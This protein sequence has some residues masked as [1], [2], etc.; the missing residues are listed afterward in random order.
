M[1]PRRGTGGRACS[2]DSS[3]RFTS[4]R[5]SYRT[6]S[7]TAHQTTLVHESVPTDDFV[8]YHEARARG[9]TGL[10]VLEATAVH[11]SGL[12]TAHTLA[13]YR[14]EIVPG[15]A[16]VARR[17][18]CLRHASLRAA[19]SRRAGADL[20]RSTPARG[21]SLRDPQPPLPRR[22]APALREGD[23]FDP[24]G[25]RALGGAGGPGRPRRS[26]DLGG[27]PVPCRS[28]L[29]ACAEPPGGR[30][31]RAGPFPARGAD[32][33]PGRRPGS[34]S[35]SASRRTRRRRQ[36]SPPMWPPTPTT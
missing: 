27:S 16:R 3:A 12:L 22:A 21:R 17:G 11:P 13:G 18:A 34:L 14:E 20:R 19:L 35:A 26:R 29:H 6:G 32:G 30:V 25:L 1:P 23:R 9:G 28:V 15:L 24:P 8:A 5:S 7:S 4:D 31:G 33:R 10:I 36:R 2:K